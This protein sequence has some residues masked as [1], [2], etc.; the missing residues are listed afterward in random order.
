MSPT[1]AHALRTTA[2]RYFSTVTACTCPAGLTV[3]L[4]NDPDPETT[5]SCPTCGHEEEHVPGFGCLAV[6]IGEDWFCACPE[7]IIP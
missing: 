1:A 2:D 5:K 3:R 4:R 7:G 6:V